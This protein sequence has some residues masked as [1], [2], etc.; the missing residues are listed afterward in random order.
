MLMLSEVQ[1]MKENGA[2]KH[3]ERERRADTEELE[4]EATTPSGGFPSSL[5][6]SSARP[7]QPTLYFPSVIRVT[8][9]CCNEPFTSVSSIQPRIPKNKDQAS[10]YSSLNCQHRALLHLRAC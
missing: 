9:W 4:R 6:S 5:G 8:A 1:Q 7:R 10:L 2:E 3:M